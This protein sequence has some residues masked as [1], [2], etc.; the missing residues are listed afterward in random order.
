MKQSR[1]SAQ[2]PLL[3]IGNK[4]HSRAQHPKH[5]KNDDDDLSH[6]A[7]PVRIHHFVLA[8]LARYLLGLVAYGLSDDGSRSASVASLAN[9]LTASRTTSLLAK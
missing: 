4:C 3:F 7:L 2:T 6:N 1:A 9:R 5:D 8:A